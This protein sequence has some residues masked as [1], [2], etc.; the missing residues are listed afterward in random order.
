MFAAATVPTE[1]GQENALLT[2]AMQLSLGPG[3]EPPAVKEAKEA[4]E[5]NEAK[6]AGLRAAGLRAAGLR[7]AG[8]RAAQQGTAEGG[9]RVGSYEHFARVFKI[10]YNV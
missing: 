3:S 4:N 1:K 6:E 10:N 8:L 2:A 5:A 7:A 9:N